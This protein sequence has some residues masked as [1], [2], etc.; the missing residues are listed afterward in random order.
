MEN[1]NV[2]ASSPLG[3]DLPAGFCVWLTS[4]DSEFLKERLVWINFDIGELKLKKGIIVKDNLLKMKLA[5]LPTR[6]SCQ[7]PWFG[8]AYFVR[9]YTTNSLS[10]PIFH[11]ALFKAPF[12]LSS[13]SKSLSLCTSLHFD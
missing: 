3:L 11:V 13:H 8:L 5:G 9:H 4:L 12:E 10:S 6:F 7:R 1:L 2:S